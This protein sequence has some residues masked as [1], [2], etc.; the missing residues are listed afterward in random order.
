MK[1]TVFFKRISLRAI[2]F[3]LIVAYLPALLTQSTL[4]IGGSANEL[5]FKDPAHKPG[6]DLKKSAACLFKT[7]TTGADAIASIDDLVNGV[8]VRKIADKI[9]LT[10]T[11]PGQ[12]FL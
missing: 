1:T 9:E 10:T 5:V 7:V 11:E 4:S 12:D 2:I 8:S 6:I 3:I